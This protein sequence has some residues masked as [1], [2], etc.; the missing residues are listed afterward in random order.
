[1]PAVAAGACSPP[2][3]PVLPG[4]WASSSPSF[5]AFFNFI[6]LGITEYWVCPGLQLPWLAD[7]GG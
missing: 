5:M 1:M 4:L 7:H 6:T 2:P 3:L